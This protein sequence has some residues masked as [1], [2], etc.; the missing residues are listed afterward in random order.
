MISLALILTAASSPPVAAQCPDMARAIRVGQAS[1]F[2]ES[3]GK[4]AALV[5][6]HGG[7]TDRRMWN[8]QFTAW[9][10]RYRVIRYDVRGFGRSTRPD[11][12]Y[13]SHDDLAAILDS[14]GVREATIIGLSLGGR[15]AVDFALTHPQRVRAL[16]LIGPGL[17]GF[18][19]SS[20]P[21]SSWVG[22]SAAVKRGD[23]SAAAEYWLRSPYM[24]PAM[25]QHRLR[26]WVRRLALENAGSWVGTDRERELDPP[27]YGRLR[28]IRAPVLAVVGA[29][30][31][32][33][34]QRIVAKLVSDL[35]NPRLVTIPGSGHMV[36]LERPVELD[37][38]IQSFLNP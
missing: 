12:E 13:G 23:S 31:I 10:S 32:P 33:D 35:P 5:L 6:I 25:E 24:K 1:L 26:A 15:I 22:I 17:S 34:I 20:A 38:A 8:Q 16:V 30:D 9:S 14:L 18:S 37:R 2:V 11:E 19:W 4:G 7:N 28:E 36:N 3:C 21:D 27:A 29:R